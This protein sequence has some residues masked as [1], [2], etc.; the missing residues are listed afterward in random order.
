MKRRG[1]CYDVGRVMWGQNWRPDLSSDELNR[2]LEIIKEDLHCNAVRIC[3]QDIDRLA[4]AAE[5]ALDLGFEVWL[6]PELWDRSPEETLD[7]IAGAAERAEELRRRRQRELVLSVGSELTL[8]PCPALARFLPV[9]PF[10]HAKL[11]SSVP[12]STVCPA[13]TL[14]SRIVPARGERISFII[15]IAS[16]IATRAPAST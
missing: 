11:R 14:T 7:Y 9:R 15:F 2:E 12:A 16:M 5:Q 1:V 10:L 6:S 4:T 13:T 8:T 3:G